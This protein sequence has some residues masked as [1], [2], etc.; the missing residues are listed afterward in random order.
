MANTLLGSRVR[1]MNEMNEMV[2][3]LTLRK[4][5]AEIGDREQANKQRIKTR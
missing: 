1:E 3:V 2:K 5:H 4:L